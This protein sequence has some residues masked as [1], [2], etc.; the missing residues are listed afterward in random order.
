[1]K[2]LYQT[3]RNGAA[4]GLLS[5][6]LLGCSDFLQITP[7]DIV[8]EDNFWNEKADIDQM[9]AGCYAS[10][11]SDNFIRRC[12]VWG[13]LRSENI[14]PGSNVQ[15]QEDLYQALRENLLTTNEY[16]KWSS[17]YDVINKCNTVIRYA[18]EVSLKDPSYRSSDVQATIAE[19]TALR[20]LC[21]FY[22][23]RAFDEV[24]FTRD[25]VTQEDQ[26]QYLPASSFDYVLGEM[27]RCKGTQFDPKCVDILLELIEEGTIDVKAMYPELKE[28]EEE[29]D[30]KQEGES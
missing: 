9:V 3:I 30:K 15:N 11:Q 22:L 18:P 4:L 17:F 7:R 21:Y 20:S 26:V 12:V 29:A 2:Q 13:E 8:T 27:K 10:M 14:Y 19:M 23:I 24:P 1:M 28:Q 25:A 6:A 16:C 5:L